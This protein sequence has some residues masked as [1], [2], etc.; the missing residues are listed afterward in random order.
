MD[1]KVTVLQ[2]QLRKLEK[3]VSSLQDSWL[4]FVQPGG[5]S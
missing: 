4:G 2:E 1:N 5:G 3:E